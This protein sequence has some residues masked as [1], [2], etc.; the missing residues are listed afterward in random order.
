[1]T[2]LDP[3]NKSSFVTL[4][5]GDLTVT[6]NLIAVSAPC[7]VR[8]TTSKSD[9]RYTETT[10]GTLNSAPQYVGVCNS[11]LSMSGFGHGDANLTAIREDGAYY[12][13]GSYAGSG[14]TFTAGDVVC[15]DMDPA[16]GVRW[17]V[18]GGSWSSW[19]S[20]PSGSA[21]Y[22][23]AMV[24]PRS[25]GQASQT[26]NF[27]GSAF[28]QAVPS[29]SAGW[30]AS[31]GTPVG[32]ADET[33]TAYALARL[34]IIATG[35]ANE[36]DTAYALAAKQ[37][38][39]T[40]LATETDTAR[41][42]GRA[43]GITRATETDTAYSLSPVAMRATGRADEAD[44]AF[45]RTA[46]QIASTGRA[47]ET[48]VALAL[49]SG[50]SATVGLAIETDTAA[51]LSALLVHGA[52]RADEADTAIALPSVHMRA[53]GLASEADEALARAPV[54]IRDVTAANEND[55]A[56]GLVPVQIRSVGIAAELDT[57]FALFP[58]DYVVPPVPHER[59]AITA[60]SN[61]H[62]E[63]AF[64]LRSATSSKG[65]RAA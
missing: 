64:A 33:D 51:A 27:G 5:N 12:V 19:V 45:A 47:N 34:Q 9:R 42:L 13:G 2:T 60:T 44:S 15:Q 35:R 22:F 59:R 17:R 63:A 56:Y 37:I 43:V 30:D 11:S 14:P 55:A 18:N 3:A 46:V 58:A 32:R 53:A 25:D 23:L 21:W 8:S 4:S 41:A 6:G 39:A 52:G 16:Q 28:A 24:D 50:Q 62:A 48:D 26:E 1:M 20:L 38:R 40:S 10:I 7:R 49:T 54:S 31:A 36:T 57:A 61:R 29:G 65:R